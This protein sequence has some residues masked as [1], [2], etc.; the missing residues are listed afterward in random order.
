MVEFHGVVLQNGRF[1]AAG[2]VLLGI[3]VEGDIVPV[4]EGKGVPHVLQETVLVERRIL[5]E[6]RVSLPQTHYTYKNR[7]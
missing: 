2:D 6:Q 1:V 4:Q 3:P 7:R 5:F